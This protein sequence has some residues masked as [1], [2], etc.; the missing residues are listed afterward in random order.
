MAKKRKIDYHEHDS[1][2]DFLSDLSNVAS[3]NES[4]G[5]MPTPPESPDEYHSYQDMASMEIPK[6]APGK[7]Q[8][9]ERRRT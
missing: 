8:G 2:P 5:M 4:T 6:K 9:A 1:M 3:A 7:S